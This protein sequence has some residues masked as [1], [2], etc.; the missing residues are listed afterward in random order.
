MNHT[1]SGLL[2]LS[3]L[4]LVPFLPTSCGSSEPLVAAA[5][6]PDAVRVQGTQVS[7]VQPAGWQHAPSFAGFADPDSY[8][9]LTIAEIAG[10]YSEVIQGFD[11]EPKLAMQRMKIVKRDPLPQGTYPGEFIELTQTSSQG[12]FIK[13]IWVFGSET[14]S[15]TVMGLCPQGSSPD[16]LERIES[17]VRS[18]SWEPELKLDPKD[19][20]KFSLEDEAGMVLMPGITGM[21]TYTSDGQPDKDRT[22]K[23]LFMLAPAIQETPGSPETYAAKRMRL[24]AGHKKIQAGELVP[25][26]IDGLS[27]YE[28]VATSIHRNS[29]EA[30]F[31][32]QVM[33]FDGA[34]HWLMQGIAREA[35]RTKQLPIFQRMARSFQRKFETL[36]SET[37]PASLEVPMDWTLRAGI[38]EEADLTAGNQVT[39]LVTTVL[40]EAKTDFEEGVTL[41]VF[42][43]DVV[44]Q[45]ADGTEPIATQEFTTDSNLRAVQNRFVF[46]EDVRTYVI[47]TIEGKDHYHQ[48]VQWCL[49]AWDESSLPA[50]QRAM[51]SFKETP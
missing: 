28:C 10:P 29:G 44:R 1:I 51:E 31:I 9:S 32:Y 17:A 21:L 11:S 7:V 39:Q 23:P 4:G 40:T 41:E 24:T 5:K 16:H 38:N 2:A 14:Q 12:S 50:L 27:G 13:W 46:D 42:T 8:S 34:S 33:L 43:A 30:A 22:G 49:T 37:V 20:L 6:H 47:T 48:I 3:L 26:T 25:I 19:E 36:Q 45:F 35:D 18:A 15:V